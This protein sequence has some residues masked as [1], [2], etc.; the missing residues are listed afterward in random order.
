MNCMQL[1]FDKDLSFSGWLDEKE[2][3]KIHLNVTLL[4]YIKTASMSS[5]SIPLLKELMNS[6]KIYGFFSC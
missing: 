4:L 5:D 6:D 1:C 2:S 3:Q